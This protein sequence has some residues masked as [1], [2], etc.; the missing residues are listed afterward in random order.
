MTLKKC[1]GPCGRLLP[2]DD[3]HF[4]RSTGDNRNFRGSCKACRRTAAAVNY[5]RNPQR[6]NKRTN[7]AR[8]IRIAHGGKA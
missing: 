5:R 3:A 6:H 4:Y 1:A 8:A 2:A 7:A